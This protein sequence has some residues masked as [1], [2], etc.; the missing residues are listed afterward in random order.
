MMADPYVHMH[1]PEHHVL[2]GMAL[3]T[4]V[5]NAGAD[6]CPRA[7]V[8]RWFLRILGLL[9]GGCQRRYVHEHTHSG[10]ASV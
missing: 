4:A 10:Y 5:H 1:G 7:G 6:T 8:S 9:R 2:V 3:L